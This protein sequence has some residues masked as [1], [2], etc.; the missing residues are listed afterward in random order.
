MYVSFWR[1][2]TRAIFCT[3]SF[4]FLFSKYLNE[5]TRISPFYGD[6]I[7]ALSSHEMVATLPLS[8]FPS[9]AYL[10]ASLLQPSG[11]NA[12]QASLSRNPVRQLSP[13]FQNPG[14]QSASPPRTT[15]RRTLHCRATASLRILRRDQTEELRYSI[16]AGIFVF[17][18]R[19]AGRQTTS[20]QIFPGLSVSSV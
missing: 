16:S 3:A 5:R 19:P 11:R 9:S 15:V 1:G 13:P 18:G 14:E 7:R 17:R 12:N 4:F 10:P 2:A 20:L 8:T 6:A